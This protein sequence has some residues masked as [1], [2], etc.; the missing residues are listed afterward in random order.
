MRKTEGNRSR[1]RFESVARETTPDGCCHV[2]V[3]LEWCGALHEATVVGIETHQGVLKSACEAAL[4]AA[5]S[6]ASDDVTLDMVGVKAVRAFDGW[7]VVIRINGTAGDD[8]Y[9]LL[10]A[11]P[12]EREED[13]PRA[14][15][16]AVLDASNRLLERYVAE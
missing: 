12:C 8:V 10:G 2:T 5:L 15:V 1:L 11:A 7:V 3:A 14:A 4:A 13:L 16:Q 9:R 6:A